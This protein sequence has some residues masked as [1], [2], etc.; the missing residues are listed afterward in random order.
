[1]QRSGFFDQLS[2]LRQ[3]IL[4]MASRVEE[5]LGK[6]VESLR[7]G[8]CSLAQWVRDDDR[9]VNYMQLSIQD[10]ASRLIA[11]HQPVARDLREL[12]SVIRMA[13]NLERMGD[14]AVHLAKTVLKI[15]GEGWNRQ[16]GILCEMGETGCVMVRRMSTAWVDMDVEA[17]VSCAAMDSQIDVLHDTLV[18]GTV[19]DLAR[20]RRAIAEGVK[21]IRTAG[22]LERFGDQ[23][24][25]SC[26][27]VVYTVTGQYRDLNE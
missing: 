27:L 6:A 16:F 20:D 24:T 26:E 5:D 14:Y 4:E 3:D 7:D 19:A 22:F 12:V 1:M 25:N 15:T 18:S 23:V 9:T 2:A 13:D 21:L 10:R 17:A 8:D 11:T